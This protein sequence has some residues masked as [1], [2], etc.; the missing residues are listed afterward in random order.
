MRE[1][2]LEFIRDMVRRGL[3]VPAMVTTDGAPGLIRAVT[4]VWRRSLRQRRL[5][6]KT[7]NILGKVP[8]AAREE[9]KRRAQDVFYAPSPE[10]AK[11]RAAEVLEDYQDFAMRSFADDLEACLAY[12]AARWPITR[13]FGRPT[14]WSGPS[15]GGAVGWKRLLLECNCGWA[16]TVLSC[17]YT[18]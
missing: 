16:R 14:C 9:V 12:C 3:K 13:P 18:R 4:E 1:N 5:A 11:E 15:S 7:G 10:T 6:H 17:P 2:L 8:K